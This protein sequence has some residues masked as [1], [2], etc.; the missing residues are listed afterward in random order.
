MIELN[1]LVWI[2]L[3]QLNWIPVILMMSITRR[4]F[5]GYAFDFEFFRNNLTAAAAVEWI[6]VDGVKFVA[7]PPYLGNFEKLV[8][9]VNLESFGF[10][11][12]LAKTCEN[13]RF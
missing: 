11:T 7:V 10:F 9:M 5:V 3:N 6:L 4:S 8:K 1:Q 12:N 2:E 13:G